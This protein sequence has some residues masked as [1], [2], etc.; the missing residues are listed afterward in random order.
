MYCFVLCREIFIFV[1]CG[2]VIVKWMMLFDVLN[3]MEVIVDKVLL[4]KIYKFM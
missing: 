4:S 3:G 1:Y 2:V